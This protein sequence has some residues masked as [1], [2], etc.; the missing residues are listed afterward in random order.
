MDLLI[1]SIFIVSGALLFF[2]P[3]VLGFIISAKL[4][5]YMICLLLIGMVSAVY[6][7]IVYLRL[8][9]LKNLIKKIQSDIGVTINRRF[10]TLTE[11][12]NLAKKYLTHEESILS[13]IAE[14]RGS[15]F[16]IASERV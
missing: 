12:L 16:L 14:L 10:D 7:I 6:I 13:E 9:S 4:S 2:H 5:I 3:L 11:L 15:P 1:A 8:L